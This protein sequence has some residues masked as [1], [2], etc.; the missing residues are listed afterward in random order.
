[1]KLELASLTTYVG[2]HLTAVEGVQPAHGCETELAN[3]LICCRGRSLRW[4]SKTNEPFFSQKAREPSQPLIAVPNHTAHAW[5]SRFTISVRLDSSAFPVERVDDV[6][7]QYIF[8]LRCKMGLVIRQANTTNR[9]LV[10]VS[11]L[12]LQSPASGSVEGSTSWCDIELT[13]YRITMLGIGGRSR[14]ATCSFCL[15]F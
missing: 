10:D 11:T 15:N 8:L 4:A 13:W 2:A 14:G 12:Y 5:F 3:K 6:P 1:M 7:N 9:D